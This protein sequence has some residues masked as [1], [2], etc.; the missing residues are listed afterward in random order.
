MRGIATRFDKLGVMYE[1]TVKLGL[2]VI[3]LGL[4]V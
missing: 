2:V 3:W 4:T 1:G